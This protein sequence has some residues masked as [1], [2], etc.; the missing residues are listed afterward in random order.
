MRPVYGSCLALH[1]ERLKRYLH[2][3][4]RTYPPHQAKGLTCCDLPAVVLT[5]G[6]SQRCAALRL[7][8]SPHQVAET[9]VLTSAR[10]SMFGPTANGP[11][12]K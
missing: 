8:F 11:D 7:V 2:V 9:A 4:V 12:Q 5:G 6:E 3:S 1:R 10:P